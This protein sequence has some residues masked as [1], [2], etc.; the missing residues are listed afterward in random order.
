MNGNQNTEQQTT[1]TPTDAAI[2]PQHTNNGDNSEQ[3]TPE[4]VNTLREEISKAQFSEDDSQAGL[5]IERISFGN[6]DDREKLIAFMAGPPFDPKSALKKKVEKKIKDRA[7]KA[8]NQEEIVVEVPDG[9]FAE[10]IHGRKGILMTDVDK[11]NLNGDWYGS[12]SHHK[13]IHDNIFPGLKEAE[14]SELEPIIY[15][16]NDAIAEIRNGAIQNPNSGRIRSILGTHFQAY[17]IQVDRKTHVVQR[18]HD[19][20]PDNFIRQFEHTTP[21]PDTPIIQ[22]IAT[23]PF[24]TTEGKCIT[25]AGYNPETFTYL[26][27]DFTHIKYNEIHTDEENVRNATELINEM[28]QEFPFDND[29]SRANFFGYLLSFP[30]RFFIQGNYPMF[31][32]TSPTPGTGKG[33]LVSLARLIW[34]GERGAIQTLPSGLNA[35]E[36]IRKELL[37]V[38]KEGKI[39]ILFDNVTSIRS[40]ELAGAITSDKFE[41]RVLGATQNAA[42]HVRWIPAAT[43]NKITYSDEILRRI[44]ECKLNAET[45]TPHLRPF[46]KEDLIG[47]VTENRTE[48]MTACLTIIKFWIK[49]G[50]QPR[51]GKPFGSFEEWTKIIGG[52]LDSIDQTE[53]LKSKENELGEEIVAWRDFCDKWWE[54]YADNEVKAADLFNIGS[55]TDSTPN[56]SNQA[57]LDL[58]NLDDDEE[59]LNLLG[60]LIYGNTLKARQ[61]AFGKLLSK[62]IDS[63]HGDYVIRFVHKDS[64]T[65]KA[66]YK[67]ENGNQKTENNQK[68]V[69]E[70]PF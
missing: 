62:S 13:I 14:P 33:M 6:K 18:M 36:N 17:W 46:K 26:T 56:Q 50:K 21:P 10:Q 44:Y 53:F 41:G 11:N 65:R 23:F 40:P 31:C 70:V 30:L 51:T 3:L 1:P 59:D 45:D 29:I 20:F 16:Q 55:Y 38:F 35:R 57:E 34:T 48:L 5:F 28:I 68:L 42:F 22:S 32:I 67:L 63:T 54:K 43:G 27:T 7:D 25:Q 19:E 37:S 64:V 15:S 49:N 69:D 12:L 4:E 60:D 52:I 24:F 9:L 58:N 39:D 2:T 47:W 66:V 8:D 61:V